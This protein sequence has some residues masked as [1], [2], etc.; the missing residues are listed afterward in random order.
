MDDGS[1]LT[2]EGYRIEP[3]LDGDLRRNGWHMLSPGG[4]WMNTFPTKR[5]ALIALDF[6]LT[7][8]DEEAQY[9]KATVAADRTHS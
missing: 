3:A 8:T 7:E 5:D 6:L 2:K 4:D 9:W 1:Y